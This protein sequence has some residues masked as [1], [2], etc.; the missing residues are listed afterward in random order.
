VSEPQRPPAA[1]NSPSGS[2][3]R[4][5]LAWRRTV[6]ATTAVGLLMIRLVVRS[7]ASDLI[8]IGIA[9][10]A[11]GWLGMLWLGQR[12]IHAIA[13][14]ASRPIGRVLAALAMLTVGFAVA[15]IVLVLAATGWSGP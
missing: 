2:A 12:R 3:E 9:A 4:T 6:L 10:A 7:G 13:D 5:R 15:A 11:V 1:D 8:G 14:E